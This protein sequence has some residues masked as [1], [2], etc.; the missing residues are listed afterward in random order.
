M[1]RPPNPHSSEFWDQYKQDLRDVLENTAMIHEHGGTCYKHLPK[2][3]RSIRDDDKDCRFQLP[4]STN[5]K[6]HF[7]D[8]GNLVLR[9][10]NGFVNGHNPLI[11]T[12]QRCNMDAKPIGSGTVAMAM[13]QYIG[14]YTV[15]FTMDTAFVFSALCAAIKVLSENPPMD[16]DGNLDAYER[17]RQFLIKS[18]N[19]LI[20]KRE[21][22]GQQ[23]ASKLIGTPNHYTNRSFPI[24]YWSAMLRE[25]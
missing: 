17:S 4:R 7:D 6:T 10:N 5:D 8:D 22:S 2:N 16:I 3:L 21:L 1:S 25:L 9:C 14:N 19:R 15:K 13:F 18:A 12:A 11:L 24:F 20:A 23:I